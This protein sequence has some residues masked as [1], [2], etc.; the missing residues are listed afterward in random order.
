VVRD[1]FH[2]QPG[3]GQSALINFDGKT[4]RA[5]IPAGKSKGVHLT[6]ITL[7]KLQGT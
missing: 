2:E 5:T 7:A 1:F 3:A 6:K 4:M